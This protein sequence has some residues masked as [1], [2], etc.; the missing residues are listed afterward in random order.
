[1][2]VLARPPTELAP[3]QLEGQST[4]NDAFKAS[5]SET[6]A[7]GPLGGLSAYAE[8]NASEGG[9]FSYGDETSITRQ[10]KLSPAV[11]IADAVQQVKDAGL[12]GQIPLERYGRSLRQETL[13]TLITM[14]QDKVRRQTLSSQYDG[15]TPQIAGMVA[16][17]IVDPA[18]IALSVIPVVGEARY[19][20]LLKNAGGTFGRF[21]VRAGVGAL[22][23]TVG[24]ALAEP[25][26][27]AGQ[28]QW[29]NDYDAY[30]SML[31]V[32]G[33]AVFG[34]LLHAGAG[35]AV[36]KFGRRVGEP[37]IEAQADELRTA[38]VDARSPDAVAAREQGID[39][40][41]PLDADR[42]DI[43][44]RLAEGRPAS[45]EEA[46][47]R[48]VD[49]LRNDIEADL[50]ARA[51]NV[52]EPNVVASAKADLATVTRE[53]DALEGQRREITK[54]RNA[55]PGV[56]RKQAE[57]L[58]DA[59][60]AERRADLEGRKTR[61]EST[62]ASNKDAAE[63]VAELSALRKGGAV[64]E[65]WRARVEAEA[66]RL[67]KP[68]DLGEPDL[69]TPLRPFIAALDQTTQAGS[70][71]M[72]M[73]QALQGQRI[74][75]TPAMLSDPMFRQDPAAYTSA[76][77]GA[78][79]N[80]ATIAG[81]DERASQAA[82]T[83]LQGA[84]DDISLE[85]ARALLADE[86]AIFREAGGDLDALDIGTPDGDLTI[87]AGKGFGLCRLRSDA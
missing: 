39:W 66:D 12:E 62:I 31:N 33:G 81:A 29:R 22:E 87:G 44:A 71:R 55:E 32:V 35:L 14:N 80:V 18:N 7:T 21:G 27:Y 30:D 23:G 4:W 86:E 83:R 24:A 16:G 25:L 79:R 59:Q 65:S 26:I 6:F 9:I 61:A 34:S 76:T 2:P 41:R 57:A 68:A 47:P 82:S 1:M 53:L 46:M 70:L 37:Q 56:T 77:E 28:Q 74:D 11:P 40:M 58:A 43:E 48:A 49:T 15:W 10:R 73:A 72:A 5:F 38:L 50:T 3:Q 51:G 42:A 45:R 67:L 78:T 85:D 17:S 13:S 20:A 75:V 52:A 19:A 63:A 69:F 60:I 64:P 8:L 54:Q 36:D 84:K